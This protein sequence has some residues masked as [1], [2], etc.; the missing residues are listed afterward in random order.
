MKVVAFP[1]CRA[2]H[3]AIKSD[4]P[5][6][7]ENLPTQGRDD[8][9]LWHD[10]WPDKRETLLLSHVSLKISASSFW[11]LLELVTKKVFPNGKVQNV[12]KLDL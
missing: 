11:P 7:P 6:P 2:I 1:C 9:T 12:G 5:V 8:L 4:R 10:E 3:R